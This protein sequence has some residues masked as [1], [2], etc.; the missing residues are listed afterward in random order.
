MGGSPG[1]FAS[2]NTA[3]LLLAAMTGFFYQYALATKRRE[4]KS[5][6]L[7]EAAGIP[8]GDPEHWEFAVDVQAKPEKGNR[9]VFSA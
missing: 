7:K 2:V 3:L 8:Y 4:P 5:C 6:C 1:V 9:H